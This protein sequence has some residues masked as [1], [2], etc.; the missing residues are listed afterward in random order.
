MASAPTWA[1][2][3]A[4]MR[5]SSTPASSISG[6]GVVGEADQPGPGVAGVGHALDVPGG[7]ELVDEVA[8]ALLGDLRGLGERVES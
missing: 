5:R 2:H 8:R 1:T 4:S 3:S 7:L 6:V